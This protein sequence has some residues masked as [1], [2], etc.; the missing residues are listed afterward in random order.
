MDRRRSILEARMPPS[1]LF[2]HLGLV[3]WEV[4]WSGLDHDEGMDE[5][6]VG[7]IRSVGEDVLL[8]GDLEEVGV[9]RRVWA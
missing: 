6:K 2:S 7:E 3:E 9:A 8:A 4:V 1:I 5:D